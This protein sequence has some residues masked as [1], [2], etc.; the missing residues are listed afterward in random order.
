V[1]TVE[2]T[3]K[4]RLEWEATAETAAG[5]FLAGQTGW[6]EVMDDHPVYGAERSI[7]VSFFD[8]RGKRICSQRERP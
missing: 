3:F 6:D 2:V 1:I 7:C 8:D 5:A 4:D